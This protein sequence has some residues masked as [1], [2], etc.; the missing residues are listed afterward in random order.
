MQYEATVPTVAD[1][2]AQT[3]VAMYLEPL[4]E[5]RFHQDSYGYR[6]GK[7]AHDALAVCRERCWKF[8]WVIDLMSRSSSMRCRG[9]S[10][11]VRSRRSPTAAGCC[12]M[13][14]G[15]CKRRYSA[16]MAPFRS[17]QRNSAG[18]GDLAG[19]GEHVLALRVRFVDGREFPGCPLSATAM[20]L[21]LSS[22]FGGESSVREGDLDAATAEV[23]HRDERVGGVEA[24]CAV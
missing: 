1:R 4:V 24:V 10:W 14:S 23:D 17:E 6:P 8:D 7:S 13:S 21:W 22:P 12:C 2:V 16:R 3:V 11:F 20:T 5:P 19:P 15:G 9:T 18:F